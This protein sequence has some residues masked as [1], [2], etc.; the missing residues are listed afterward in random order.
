[1]RFI[2]IQNIPSKHY[3]IKKNLSILNSFYDIIDK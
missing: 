3:K 1:M 2:A